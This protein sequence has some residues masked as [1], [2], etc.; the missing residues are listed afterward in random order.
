MAGGN[1]RLGLGVCGDYL[2]GGDVEAAWR[3][4]DEL[5]DTLVAWLDSETVHANAA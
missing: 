1:A 4:G 3:S 2:A 5:A